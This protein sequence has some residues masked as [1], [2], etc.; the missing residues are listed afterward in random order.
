[1]RREIP[2]PVGRGAG[3]R[4]PTFQ[5]KGS[6]NSS[7]NPRQDG[8][9]IVAHLGVGESAPLA[10]P[11]FRSPPCDLYRSRQTTRAA[12]RSIPRRVSPHDN[13]SPRRNDRTELASGTSRRENVSRASAA[14]DVFPGASD[15]CEECARI[16]AARKSWAFH[17]PAAGPLT[18]A[19]L[20]SGEGFA[21]QAERAGVAHL[22]V[23][24]RRR[25]VIAVRPSRR[26]GLDKHA[27]EIAG[28]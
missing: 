8:F 14:K 24:G 22:G 2:S 6:L 20:P 27:A 4:G 3:V 5:T 7:A 26:P 21:P 15:A 9:K 1:M 13:R 28:L 17:A 19:P 12:P 18:P 11:I 10:R 23:E 25:V 16:R